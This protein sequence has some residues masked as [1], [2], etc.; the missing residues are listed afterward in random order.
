MLR[1]ATL[2][3]NTLFRYTFYQLSLFIL[4]IGL[5]LTSQAMDSKVVYENCPSEA[6][7]VF[8][9]SDQQD[10][11]EPLIINFSI[12]AASTATP[13]EDFDNLPTSIT[14]P[15][16]AASVTLPVNIIADNEEESNESLVLSPANDCQCTMPFN[17]LLIAEVDP[18]EVELLST[19]ICAGEF[20][21][22]V[23]IVDGGLP[24]FSYS[25]S[26]GATTPTIR[27]APTATSSYTLNVRDACGG[28]T[29]ASAE[30]EVIPLPTARLL[31]SGDICTGNSSVPVQVEL[32][33]E[34]PWELTY[35]IDGTAQTPV[36]I[37]ASPHTLSLSDEGSYRLT[38][39]TGAGGCEGTASGNVTIERV[40]LV[41]SYTDVPATCFGISDGAIDLEVTG[42]S[43]PY[44]YQWSGG[45][46]A[47]P[48]HSNV[49]A[50]D[51]A[52]L[53]TDANGCTL[54]S[55]VSVRTPALLE[56]VNLRLRGSDCDLSTSI[57]DLTVEGG[58]APYV[59]Q[60]SHVADDVEDP[61]NVSVGT[62]NVQIT[63]AN[64]C[65]A[66]G[67]ITVDD[68][69][70][71]ALTVENIQAANCA[72]PEG[73]AIDL[74]VNGG[75]SPYVYNW[76]N[77]VPNQQDPTGLAPNVY[78]VEVVDAIGC[79]GNTTASVPGDFFPPT[80][81]AGGDVDLIC[82]NS[83]I[84]LSGIGSSNGTE[85]TYRWSSADGFPI[86]DATTNLPTV[87]D[88]GSFT[89][90]VTDTRN[91]C[92]A[93]DEVIVGLDPSTP[94]A[95]VT[96]VADTL[97]CFD[98]ELMV[99]GQTSNFNAGF[100]ALWT[101]TN[102]EIVEG[103]N[104]LSATVTEGGYYRLRVSNPNTGCFDVD[105]TFVNANLTPPKADGG[106]NVE[107]NCN[108]NELTIGGRNSS[109]GDQFSYNWSTDD[110]TFQGDTSRDS[111][112]VTTAGTYVF[113][114]RNAE[115]GCEASDEI[116]VIDTSPTDIILAAAPPVCYGEK[117]SIEIV[118]VVGGAGPYFYS[119]DDG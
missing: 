103:E 43:A 94:Y 32:T 22:L 21:E 65:I 28:N 59:Y 12:A 91:G 76:N 113:T 86:E 73:G 45:L 90:V 67:S 98:P 74:S 1:Y 93:S 100:E 106:T 63:D 107:L 70:N 25:W 2:N 14:I 35:S 109:K 92:T 20:V 83:G 19:R 31:G 71:I 61:G 104:S 82:P 101:T 17:E 29:S 81:N 66:N 69:S 18:L 112:L 80:A 57:I 52:L 24:D 3:H 7:F 16:G 105:S 34:G 72:D 23:P 95:R 6:F 56:A 37:S 118:D 27:V 46:P 77:D 108:L 39:I 49:A 30:V 42:G 79:T 5:P 50:G 41:A 89:I 64:G 53:V 85:Y 58:M 47:Q 9:R 114:V 88:P 11:S 119:I 40:A 15:A 75:F 117:G 115:N 36:N 38:D 110:G 99:D 55:T 26:N 60:W 33:G 62:F 111:I 78:S 44:Q 54:R 97:T 102:G 48:N 4:M 87:F 84:F 116:L 10:R 13:G 8:E 51:Y 68:P 96:A